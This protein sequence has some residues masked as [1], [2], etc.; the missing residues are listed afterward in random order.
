MVMLLNWASFVLTGVYA[1]CRILAFMPSVF[2]LNAL[3]L[4]IIMPSVL[5]Q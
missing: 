1:D 4:S 5:A 3:L 2:M